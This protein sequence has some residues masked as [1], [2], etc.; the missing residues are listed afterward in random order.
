MGAL[1]A[2]FCGWAIAAATL[3]DSTAAIN[4]ALSAMRQ[5]TT[6]CFARSIENVAAG[7]VYLRMGGWLHIIEQL[8]RGGK[9]LSTPELLSTTEHQ[10]HF[11]PLERTPGDKKEE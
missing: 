11:C 10:P 9:K 3:R 1:P 6:G 5:Y 8:E 4:R 7:T 2:R